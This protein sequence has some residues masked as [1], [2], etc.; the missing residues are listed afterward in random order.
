MGINTAENSRPTF[1]G[2]EVNN[3]SDMAFLQI[4]FA[5]LG[6]SKYQK[7]KKM[8][9]YLA[10]TRCGMKKVRYRKDDGD[11]ILNLLKPTGYVTHHQ[12]NI[13]QL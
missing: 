2:L 6:D 12:F 1:S 13:Q 4:K 7:K 8:N 3:C 5:F 11:K 9:Y 10:V